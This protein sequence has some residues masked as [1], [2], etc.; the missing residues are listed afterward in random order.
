M[1]DPRQRGRPSSPAA[2]TSD[3]VR[4]TTFGSENEPPLSRWAIAIAPRM[5]R[6]TSLVAVL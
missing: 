3:G 1:A 2:A 6:W 5:L 4:S